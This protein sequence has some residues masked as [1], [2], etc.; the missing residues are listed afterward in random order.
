MKVKF[1]YVAV[2]SVILFV[3]LTTYLA[4][5]PDDDHPAKTKE[6]NS[7]VRDENLTAGLFSEQNSKDFPS[8]SLPESYLSGSY[9]A[10]T[11]KELELN[12]IAAKGLQVLTGRRIYDKFVEKGAILDAQLADRILNETLTLED[13]TILN[14]YLAELFPEEENFR[15]ELS[16]YSN[17]HELK[18]AFDGRSKKTGLFYGSELLAQQGAYKDAT[19]DDIEKLIDAGATLPDDAIYKM[20]VS[21][22]IDLAIKLKN[23]GYNIK[24]DYIENFS[25]MN[26]IELQAESYA[27]NPYKATAE[28]QI[29]NIKKLIE[30]GVP[31]EVRD[32]TRNALDFVLEGVYNNDPDQARKL[33][34]LAVGLIDEGISVQQSHFQLMEK[35][36]QKHA[37]LYDEY[38]THIQ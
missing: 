22:N 20:M 33:L 31:L 17:F 25:S 9:E 28:E 29:N 1:S 6:L 35:I 4:L 5:M 11:E 24:V 32:G 36:K 38:Q 15:A 26:T 27:I 12:K 3:S 2:P 19:L 30:L 18:N 34:A 21:D 14:M 8:Q 16:Q 7:V 23:A 37:G 10:K 13:W